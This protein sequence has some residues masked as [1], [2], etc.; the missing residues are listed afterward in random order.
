MVWV[1]SQY[2]KGRLD[3]AAKMIGYYQSVNVCRMIRLFTPAIFIVLISQSRVCAESS[4]ISSDSTA[5]GHQPSYALYYGYPDQFALFLQITPRFGMRFGLKTDGLL[6]RDLNEGFNNQSIETSIDYLVSLS[7]K[8]N[9]SSYLGIGPTLAYSRQYQEYHPT[10]LAKDMH[11]QFTWSLGVRSIIGTSWHIHPHLRLF[12]EFQP[13]L[14]YRYRFRNRS[15]YGM[16][17]L[18]QEYSSTEKWIVW[19]L[20]ETLIGLTWY[21]R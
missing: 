12:T 5:S 7:P 21:F 18:V 3:L 6:S 2:I 11:K 15:M 19:S 17:E 10:E 14:G 4:E 20:T 8:K 9:Y 13:S 16:E 1:G